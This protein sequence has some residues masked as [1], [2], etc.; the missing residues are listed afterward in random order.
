MAGFFGKSC[1]AGHSEPG[2]QAEG[3]C[4]STPEAVMEGT[5]PRGAPEMEPVDEAKA[6][7]DQLIE[8]NKCVP[9]LRK[10]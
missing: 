7:I 10:M 5:S 8:N 1:C 9:P 3:T 4:T 2:P 6:D